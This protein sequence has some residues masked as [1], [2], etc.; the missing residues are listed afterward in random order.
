MKFSWVFLVWINHCHQ[1]KTRQSVYQSINTHANRHRLSCWILTK[2]I[3]PNLP[4]VYSQFY[5]RL[6]IFSAD[7]S[8]F[9]RL[10]RQILFFRIARIAQVSIY[11]LI[12]SCL[13]EVLNLKISKET[14]CDRSCQKT[15]HK[16]SVPLVLLRFMVYWSR[17]LISTY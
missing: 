3:F 8:L 15:W 5:P 1:F 12:T 9:W 17:E 16:W 2:A 6:S 7:P 4:T 13:Q 10:R 14:E 11:H